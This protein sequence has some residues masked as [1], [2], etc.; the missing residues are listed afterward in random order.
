MA[1]KKKRRRFSAAFKAAAIEKMKR[2]DNVVA[3]GRQLKI[4][5]RQLYTWQEAAEKAAA[6]AEKNT[7]EQREAALRSENAKLKAAL[8]DKT[9]EVDFFKGALQ[10]IEALRQK[11]GPKGGEAFTTKSGK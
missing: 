2:C 10:K 8:A 7:A 11:H 6:A 3:L 1:E 9:L 4:H 5:W